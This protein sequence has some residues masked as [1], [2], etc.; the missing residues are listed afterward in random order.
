[1]TVGGRL[2]VTSIMSILGRL[3]V[4]LMRSILGYWEHIRGH[5]QEFI[6]TWIEIK[7]YSDIHKAGRVVSQ[8]F[9]S[10]KSASSIFCCWRLSSQ[11]QWPYGSLDG[12]AKWP[13]NNGHTC[14]QTIALDRA[15]RA[16][17]ASGS[18]CLV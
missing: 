15:G 9:T 1:M 18:G 12:Y 11:A 16:M 14:T 4:T 6:S 13:S 7:I 17:Q 3:N 5:A 2:N 10:V 8:L